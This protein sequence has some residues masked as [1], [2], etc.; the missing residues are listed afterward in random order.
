MQTLTK[1]ILLSV[2]SSLFVAGTQAASLM[3]N[4]ESEQQAALN[5]EQM[6]QLL[7][8]RFPSAQVQHVTMSD[9]EGLYS[10]MLQGD[11]YYVS[12]NGKYLI[13]GQMLDI[14]T[15]KVRNVTSERVAEIQKLESPMRK[16]EINALDEEDMVVYQA[17]NEK[18][19]ITIFT[20]VDCGYCQK[21]H[22]ERQEYLD[23]GITLRYLAFP[24]A[25]LTSKSAEKL[26]G[27]W[28]AADQQTA[29]T[30][31]K[32]QHKYRTGNCKTPFRE[33]MALVRKF[34]LNGTPGIILENG[35]LIGGYLQAEILRERLDKLFGPKAD[36]KE[37]ATK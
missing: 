36:T 33:H 23:R 25:G 11:L 3:K 30:E 13:K 37:I 1:Y 14:S 35:D 27:I 28:C 31:A 24:R 19:V 10:F 18:H 8:E 17:P 34:G 15:P 22:R 21:M 26:R 2:I 6:Q 32:V 29:M 12:D 16:A 20:D 9:I 7:Q 5:Q 4:D